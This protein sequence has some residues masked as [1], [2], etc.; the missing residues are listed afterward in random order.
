MLVISVS[1]NSPITPVGILTLSQFQRLDLSIVNPWLQ[2]MKLPQ[3]S[4]DDIKYVNEVHRVPGEDY[5][6]AKS[7]YASLPGKVKL[8]NWDVV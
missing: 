8:L 2:A 6:D 5:E 7:F 4:E 3:M 1:T